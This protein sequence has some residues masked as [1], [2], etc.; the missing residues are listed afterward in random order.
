MRRA[1]NLAAQEIRLRPRR[2]VGL[3]VKVVKFAH[4]G[5]AGEEHF[6]E[7]HARDVEHVFTREPRHRSLLNVR[8][9][10]P[11]ALLG[12]SAEQAQE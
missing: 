12:A 10:L 5:N 7:R 9:R 11:A 1:N 6:H 3:V 8:L 2:A 4:T